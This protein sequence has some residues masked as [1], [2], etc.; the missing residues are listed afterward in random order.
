MLNYQTHTKEKIVCEFLVNPKL[1]SGKISNFT[2]E[3]H[4]TSS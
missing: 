4:V 3:S 1:F 2:C